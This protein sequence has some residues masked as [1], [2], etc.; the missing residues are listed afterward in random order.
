M[1][2]ERGKM[3]QGTWKGGITNLVLWLTARFQGVEEIAYSE[4]SMEEK[5]KMILMQSVAIILEKQQNLNFGD[6]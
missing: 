4:L 1:R 5:V 6:I 2:K 3:F